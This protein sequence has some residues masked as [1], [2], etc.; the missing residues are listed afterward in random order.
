MK[1][2]FIEK[3]H[4][5]MKFVVAKKSHGRMKKFSTEKL[6]TNFFLCVILFNIRS[7]AKTGFQDNRHPMTP[8]VFITGKKKSPM[9]NPT[10]NGFQDLAWPMIFL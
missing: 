9:G 1:I 5:R 7:L 4:N 10:K 6:G 8:K 3:N 2:F